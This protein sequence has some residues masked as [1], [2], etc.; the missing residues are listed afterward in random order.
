MYN[1]DRAR[2]QTLIDYGFRL[3]SA[4]DNRPMRFE[5][6]MRKIPQTIYVSATPNEW[7]MSRAEGASLPGKTTV[8]EQ[9]VRPTGLIDP[10]IEVRGTT[11]QIDDLL[12]EIEKRVGVHER[13]LVTTLTKRMAEDLSKYIEE[14]GIKVTYLHSDV[15][16]LDR[17]DILSDLRSGVFDVVVGINLLREGLDLPEVSLVAILDA[18]KEGFLRSRTSLVQTMG[19]AARHI[20]GRVIMYADKITDSMQYAIDEVTR[21]RGIQLEYNKTHGITPTSIQ[22]PIRDRMVQK[23]EEV[24]EK[25]ARQL[26]A[27]KKDYL[28]GLTPKD[29]IDYKKKIHASMKQAAKD[30]NFELAAKLRDFLKT[31]E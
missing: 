6:F 7:E 20:E 18:D 17:S 9:L 15:E 19:R 23:A 25:T 12:R 13:V 21:R 24:E 10:E 5:E 2:K 1:G 11:G 16:T 28:D 8:V 14:H 31:L 30:L 4:L 26:L 3:P 22:K 29:M 27:V